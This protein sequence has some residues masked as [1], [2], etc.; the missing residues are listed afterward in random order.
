MNEPKLIECVKLRAKLSPLACL[1]NRLKAIALKE[2]PNIGP[3]VLT[4][5]LKCQTGRKVRA[6]LPET[7]GGGE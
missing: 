6:Y 2:H 5:C 3:G 4:V 1:A 7:Q